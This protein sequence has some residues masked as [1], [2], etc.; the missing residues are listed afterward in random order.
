MFG[1]QTDSTTPGQNGPSNNA[2][3]SALYIPQI[4]RSGMSPSDS[5]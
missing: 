1:T 2:Y 4:P 5:F 3:R